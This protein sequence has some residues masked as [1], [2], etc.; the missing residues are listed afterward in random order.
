MWLEKK[1]I[2]MLSNTLINFKQKDQNVFNF[3]CPICGDS[4]SHRSKS[5]GYLISKQGTF[6][7]YCHNC[8]ASLHFTKFLQ[9]INNQLYDEF[10]T[11]KFSSSDP[12]SVTVQPVLKQVK[13][14]PNV[15]KDLKKVSQLR[16]THKCKLYVVSRQIPTPYHSELYYCP[17][18]KEWT[19]TIIDKKFEDVSVDSARL[20][21]PLKD[22]NGEVF[23]YQG[24]ALSSTDKLKYITIM[25]DETKP[26]IFGLHKVDL[27]KRYY[28]FEGPIDSMFIENSIATCGGSLTREMEIL[29]KN[30]SNAVVVYDNEPRNKQIIKGILTA[31]EK[32]YK[33]C[34]WPE[35][36]KHKDINDM[37]LSK[38]SGEYCKTELISRASSKIQNIIDD[39]TFSG[40]E[41]TLRL[42][43][44]KN[45]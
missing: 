31:I 28:I 20:I 44:F 16:D 7:F 9:T 14:I 1:Y 4:K 11:E 17:K 22:S 18:F 45:C 8:N 30:T 23:G 29:N 27:N 3:K 2:M 15:F 33:V 21:I 34:I 13:Q 19:N 41:A 5:R 6:F 35:G 26:R 36:T 38:V 32:G 25:M 24:R 12:V 42:T 43:Q 10:I 40:L 39:N 37:I